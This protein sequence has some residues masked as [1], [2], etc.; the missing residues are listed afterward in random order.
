MWRI[1]GA[2]IRTPTREL[3]WQRGRWLLP[4]IF[5]VVALASIV[6]T[7]FALSRTLAIEDQSRLIANNALVS[8]RVLA[9]MDHDVAQRRLLLD[10][11]VLLSDSSSTAEIE[12]EIARMDEDLAAGAKTYE[13]L[14]TFPGERRLWDRVKAL[15]QEIEPPVARVLEL[16]RVNRNAEAH[17]L[18]VTTS[19]Q[20][21][22]LRNGLDA[23]IKINDGAANRSIARI[24]SLRRSLVV[25]FLGIG[26]AAILG[27]LILGRWSVRQLF[28]RDQQAARYAR[29]LEERNRDLDAFAGHVAHDI[30]GPLSTISLAAEQLAR[31]VPEHAK[32]TDLLRRGVSQMQSFIEDL[33]A[34]AR[35]Q[36][37]TGSCDPAAVCAKVCQDFANRVAGENGTLR[38]A[39]EHAQVRCTEGLL[40]QAL[41]NLLGNAIKYRRVDVSLQIEMSGAITDGAYHLR[42]TDNGMGMSPE[43]AARAFEPFYRAT[44][45]R[46]LPGTGLGLS[47]VKRVVD[48]SGGAVSVTSRIGQGATFTVH[49]PLAAAEASGQ[50]GPAH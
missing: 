19:A 40:Q 39:V 17:D 37:I 8:V 9:R 12:R 44:R 23:L 26:T 27:L 35:V 41:V 33:L 2:R 20:F 16:S 38:C 45:T 15:N 42:V 4:L 13:P 14:A 34:L 43:D 18:L 29:V 28:Q 25:T 5:T 36:A 30:R 47:I 21:R 10:E 31:V 7:A 49:L 50:G 6:T 1:G 3:P 48:A 32:T 22:E 24:A 46:G 11:H